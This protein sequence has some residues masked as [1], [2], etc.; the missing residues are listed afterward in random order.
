MSL[1][2][3]DRQGNQGKEKLWVNEGHLETQDQLS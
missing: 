2:H 1:S 3:P